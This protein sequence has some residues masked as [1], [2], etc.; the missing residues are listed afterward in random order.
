MFIKKKCNTKVFNSYIY[1]ITKLY[2][3]LQ[4]KNINNNIS[5]QD[6][7]FFNNTRMSICELI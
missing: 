4:M 3:H 1:D 5:K 6:D 2:R 7:E